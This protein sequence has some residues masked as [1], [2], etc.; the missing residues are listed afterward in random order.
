M[1]HKIFF[2]IKMEFFIR[3]DP[4]FVFFSFDVKGHSITQTWGSLGN[5]TGIEQP[6]KCNSLW[7]DLAALVK[8]FKI[9]LCAR[10]TWMMLKFEKHICIRIDLFSIFQPVLFLYLCDNIN[11]FWPKYY[12]FAL[13]PNLYYNTSHIHE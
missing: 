8:K 1:I 12:I 2:I 6:I 9:W 11:Y 13:L 7:K 4:L 5:Q 10:G 3:F